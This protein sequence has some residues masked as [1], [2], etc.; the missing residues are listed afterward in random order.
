MLTKV[1]LEN[2]FSFA[3][4]TTIELNPEINV[5][6]GINGSGKS[7]FLKA[8]RLLY[9]SIAGEGFEKTFLRD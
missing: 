2:F 3:E 8:I 6:I 4:P 7:N 5:L 1:T 9:D